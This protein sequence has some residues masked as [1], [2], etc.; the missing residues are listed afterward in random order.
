MSDSEYYFYESQANN[1]NFII[2]MYD[3]VY[4]KLLLLLKF[5]FK[6]RTK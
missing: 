5:I 6:K 4:P 2:N 1:N 3:G